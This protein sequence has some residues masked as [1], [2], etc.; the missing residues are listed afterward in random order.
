M[1]QKQQK[2][3]PIPK[4]PKRKTSMHLKNM[5]GVDLWI[6]VTGDCVTEPYTK[7]EVWYPNN[8]DD[9]L[10]SD[11]TG[12][13]NK[14]NYDFEVWKNDNGK[15]GKKFEPNFTVPVRNNAAGAIDSVELGKDGNELVVISI[16]QIGGEIIRIM[17]PD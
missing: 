3:I 2:D 7:E 13:G 1:D 12:F 10:E 16:K 15:P 17:W 6:K 9:L 4:P 8:K 11:E 14:A 5:T